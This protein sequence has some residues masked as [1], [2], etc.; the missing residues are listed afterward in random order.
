MTRGRLKLLLLLALFAAPVLA[1]WLA[2]AY[3][4]SVPAGNYGELL[5]PAPLTLP[6]LTDPAGRAAPG[7]TLR[8]RW[9]L[10]VAAPGGC[11]AACA[12]M[13]H[14]ARQ[15]RLAQGREQGR[16]ERVLLGTPEQGWPYRDGA[17]VGALAPLA[18]AR[19]LYLVDPLGNLMMRFPDGA[20]GEGVIGDLRRLLKASGAG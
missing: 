3:G 14:L 13:V 9:L 1:A 2:H 4:P 18:L 5:P 17:Y 16:V 6:T 8:G 19:G 20:D 7:E 11:D 15:V 10:L 12:R